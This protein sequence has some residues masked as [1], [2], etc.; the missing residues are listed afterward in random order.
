MLSNGCFHSGII[1]IK[2]NRNGNNYVLTLLTVLI[3]S[4]EMFLLI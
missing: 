1:L 2:N 4:C 3:F